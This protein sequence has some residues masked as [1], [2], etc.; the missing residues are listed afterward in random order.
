MT[1]HCVFAVRGALP[2]KFIDGKMAQGRT[3]ISERRTAHSRKP[4]AM[5][6]MLEQVS[7]GPYL[8]LFGRTV[9]KSWDA[10]GLQLGEDMEEAPKR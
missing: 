5:R 7:Y 4:T 3:L 2:Y 9:P 6:K 10:I 1:E 8:E